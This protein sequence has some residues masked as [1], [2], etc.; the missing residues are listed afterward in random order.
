MKT[1]I[2]FSRHQPTAEQI[3]GASAIGYEIKSIEPGK[4]LGTVELNDNSDI[5]AVVSGL[6]AQVAEQKAI[7]IFGMWPND[8]QAQFA[9]T[10]A[11]AV[12][13]GQYVLMPVDGIAYQDVPCFGASNNMRSVEGGKPT[14]THRE[15]K[16][17][18]HLSQ[19][20]CRWL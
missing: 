4:M 15:W 9:R 2:W 18:G 20:S 14:F 12:S 11:D 8:M 17:V 13:R 10:A 3:A 16:L 5:K 19:A 6:L 1:A 7:A